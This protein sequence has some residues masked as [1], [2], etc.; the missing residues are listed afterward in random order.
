MIQPEPSA[1]WLGL[2]NVACGYGPALRQNLQSIA[3]IKGRKP[4]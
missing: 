4:P 2:L 1:E 3:R